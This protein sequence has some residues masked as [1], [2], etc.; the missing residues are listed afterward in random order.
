MYNWKHP[1]I[2]LNSSLSKY[3]SSIKYSDEPEDL[4]TI[5]KILQKYLKSSDTKLEHTKDIQ[6]SVKH[7]KK[8]KV[9]KSNLRTNYFKYSTEEKPIL[10][11]AMKIHCKM[12]ALRF[13][14]IRN[15]TSPSSNNS[16]LVIKKILQSNE[17]KQK[18]IFMKKNSCNKRQN[19]SYSSYSDIF[20]GL[21][22]K[23][24]LK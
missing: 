14:K 16:S 12:P 21:L 11:D 4:N 2:R 18:R 9:K 22:E 5:K 1:G 15:K 19:S 7:I 24:P 23:I 8:T 10:F 13:R 3:K 20:R 17:I 6:T